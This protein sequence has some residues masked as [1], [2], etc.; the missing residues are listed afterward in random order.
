VQIETHSHLQRLHVKRRSAITRQPDLTSL[1]RS[2]NM[3]ESHSRVANA[4][5]NI[6]CAGSWPKGCMELESMCADVQ[7]SR[8]W[9]FLFMPLVKLVL[10]IMDRAAACKIH[11]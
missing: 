3:S 4:S 2:L 1:Y 8:I 6:N 7:I 9:Q 5:V 10:C 11:P